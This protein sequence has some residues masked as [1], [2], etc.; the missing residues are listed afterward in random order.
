MAPLEFDALAKAPCCFDAFF[1]GP[2]FL[3]GSADVSDLTTLHPLRVTLTGRDIFTA[4][5]GWIFYVLGAVNK[6]RY[7]RNR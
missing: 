1:V 3:L 6:L 4:S 5:W 2:C 7:I